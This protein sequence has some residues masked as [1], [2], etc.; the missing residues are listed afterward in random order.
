MR[1]TGITGRSIAAA[2]VLLVATGSAAVAIAHGDAALAPATQR[3]V[4][5]PLAEAPNCWHPTDGTPTTLPGANVETI[6]LTIEATSLLAVDEQG[7]VTAAETNTGCAPQP[8]D[9]VYFVHPDGNLTEAIGFDVS[10]LHFAG[11]FREFGYHPVA[12]ES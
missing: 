9:H 11:D 3:I 7:R 6:T 5:A 12:T 8:G 2:V 10:A 1:H 4:D